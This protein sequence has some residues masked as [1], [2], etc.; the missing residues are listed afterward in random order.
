MD[1]LTTSSNDSSIEWR[2]VPGYKGRY[3]VSNTGLIRRA[4]ANRQYP[5]HSLLTIRTGQYGYS[6]VKLQSSGKQCD[7]YLHRLIMLAFRG[8]MR[9][10]VEAALKKERLILAKL[11]LKQ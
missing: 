1:Y 8:D 7:R 5:K 2:P 10:E 6:V 4:K 3:E 9:R 11:Q